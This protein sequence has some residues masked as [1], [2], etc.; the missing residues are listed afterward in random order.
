MANPSGNS[1]A[2]RASTGLN[3]GVDRTISANGSAARAGTGANRRIPVYPPRQAAMIVRKE[4][5][6]FIGN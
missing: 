3:Q 6:A 4:G 1:K 2:L 5:R